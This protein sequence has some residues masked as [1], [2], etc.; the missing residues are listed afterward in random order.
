MPTLSPA[1]HPLE[2]AGRVGYAFK[3]VLYV[4]LGVLAV[5][6]ARDGGSTEGQRGALQ[7]VAETSFGG[8]LLTLLAIGLAAYAVWRLAMAALDPEGDG[9]DAE[10]M[11]HRIGY[12]VSGVAYGLLAFAAYRILQGS[13]GGSGNGAEEGAATALSLPGGRWVL[14]LVAL[15]VLAYGVYELIRAWRGSFMD[16]LALD[17]QAARHRET[18]QRLGQAGLA[19]RGVVYSIIGFALG[20]RCLSVQS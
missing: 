6:T 5:D 14:A 4:L 8:V 1:R 18:I 19:A 9:T 7:A 3:G 13:G 2:T 20:S 17:G 16:K 10:G 15:V 12:V 11:A